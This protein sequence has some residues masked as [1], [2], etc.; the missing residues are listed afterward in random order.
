MISKASP[1]SN[2]VPNQKLTM[3]RNSGFALIQVLVGL[4]IMA[5]VGLGVTTLIVNMTQLQQSATQRSEAFEVA[6]MISIYLSNTDFC[7]QNLIVEPS[8]G[9]GYPAAKL[10][11]GIRVT[12]LQNWSSGTPV[13]IYA[14]NKTTG[15]ASG[16]TVASMTINPLVGSAPPTTTMATGQ[17]DLVFDSKAQMGGGTKIQSIPV[18]FNIQN[19]LVVSCQTYAAGTGTLQV[20]EC[21]PGQFVRGVSD[22]GILICSD[23]PVSACTAG[24]FAIG[25]NKDGQLLCDAPKIPQFKWVQLASNGEPIAQT[26]ARA[27]MDPAPQPNCASGERRPAGNDDTADT[28][29]INYKYGVWGG[30]NNVGG[31]AFGIYCYSPKQ[32]HDSD[33][34]DISVSYRCQRR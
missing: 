22:S 24:S 4:A 12:Q 32:K 19:G 27:G 31:S 21:K 23:F 28:D 5:S 1:C 13:P 16:L 7:T 25:I 6:R 11:T 17:L 33:R 2:Q 34:T 10:D 3:A 18:L 9:A 15:L 26:C 20:Q 14:T 30:T 29:R 8:S